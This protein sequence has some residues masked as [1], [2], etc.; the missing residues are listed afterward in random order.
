MEQEQ[1]YQG[2]ERRLSQQHYEGDDRRRPQPMIE[3][4]TGDLDKGDPSMSTAANEEEQEPEAQQEQKDQ[5]E[6]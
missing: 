5:P 6:H 2:E 1:Q 3:E 4:P